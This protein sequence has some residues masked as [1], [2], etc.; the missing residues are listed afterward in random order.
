MPVYVMLTTLTD[1]GRKTVKSNPKRLK[2]V[3]R[4]VEAMG[5]KILAQYALLGPYDFINILEAPDNKTITK[6]ALELGSRGTL[7]TM[8]M[9]AMPVDDLT[10]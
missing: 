7:Q 9:A 1:E 8:T 6:L 5:V 4:E 10:G 2:E 3:N